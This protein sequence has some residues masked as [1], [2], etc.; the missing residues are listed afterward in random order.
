MRRA[1]SLMAVLLVAAG[2]AK[3]L[4]NEMTRQ[5]LRGL[6]GVEVMVENLDPEAEADGLSKTMIQTDVELKLRQA[7]IRVLT[8]DQVLAAAGRPWLLIHASTF[9][10]KADPLYAYH[11]DVR[12]EQD[13]RLERDPKIMVILATTWSALGRI[14]T[15]G[16]EKLPQI[17]DDI[18]DQVDQF[19]NAW[20]SVNPSATQK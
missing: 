7:G 18:K 16:S 4:D 5:S 19:I 3:A 12:L 8:K 13:V 10:R 20:L 9:R 1:L 15:V 14:G 6:K 11:L 2:S 17:R